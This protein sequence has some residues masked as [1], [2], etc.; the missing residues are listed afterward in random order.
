MRKID[1]LGV[2]EKPITPLPWVEYG[3][4]YRDNPYVSKEEWDSIEE[5]RTAWFR[6]VYDVKFPHGASFMMACAAFDGQVPPKAERVMWRRHQKLQEAEREAALI[7]MERG[8]F[9]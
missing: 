1:C 2:I 3:S 7:A 8:Y 5:V 9:Q 4:H 6:D